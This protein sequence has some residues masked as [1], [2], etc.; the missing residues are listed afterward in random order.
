MALPFYLYINIYSQ[1]SL[2]YRYLDSICKKSALLTVNKGTMG[3]AIY[4]H[5]DEMA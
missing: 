1:L 5:E 2:N 3:P 4:W